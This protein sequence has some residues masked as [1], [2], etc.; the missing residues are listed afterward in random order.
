L[1]PRS[2]IEAQGPTAHLPQIA[3]NPKSGNSPFS[4]DLGTFS[5]SSYDSLG[6]RQEKR[7]NRLSIQEEFRW[8]QMMETYDFLH[9]VKQRVLG[10]SEPDKWFAVLGNS[11]CIFSLVID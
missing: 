11:V 10:R 4:S 6:K 2:Y 1:T 8:M 3:H 9:L 5:I 7:Y